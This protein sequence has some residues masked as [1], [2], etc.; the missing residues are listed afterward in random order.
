MGQDIYGK[1]CSNKERG[2]FFIIGI[3][4]MV[5]YIQFS[6]FALKMAKLTLQKLV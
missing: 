5:L 1:L 6:R 2:A 3:Y 4:C